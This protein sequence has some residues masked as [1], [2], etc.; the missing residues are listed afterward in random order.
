[1][2]FAPKQSGGLKPN[3]QDWWP[4]YEPQAFP[5]AMYATIFN[6]ADTLAYERTLYTLEW[7]NPRP[8]EEISRIEVRVNPDAGPALAL[9][10]VTALV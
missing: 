8:K 4:E 7:I 10:A 2:P 5:H 6:P 1:M 9:I 3:L